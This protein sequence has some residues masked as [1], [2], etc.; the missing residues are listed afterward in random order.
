MFFDAPPD[1]STYMI[2]GYAVFFTISIIYLISLSIRWSN[3]KRDLETLEDMDHK[4][5]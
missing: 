3:L 5:K 2:V 4:Q 1:T